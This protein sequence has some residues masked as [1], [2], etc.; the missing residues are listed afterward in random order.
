MTIFNGVAR[1]QFST[2]IAT[3]YL[4]L[5]VLFS[6]KLG[7]KISG[8][9]KI[10]YLIL[11]LISNLIS[12][13]R[14]LIAVYF[15]SLFLYIL[16]VPLKEK[17]R[18]ALIA[19]S[20]LISLVFICG[21]ENFYNGF[22]DRYT[23][24]STQISDSIRIEQSRSL[25]KEYQATPYFGKGLGGYAKD[26]IRSTTGNFNMHSYEVQWLAFLMQFGIVGILLIL[27]PICLIAFRLI[28]PQ[29]SLISISF[30]IL[31]ALWI[32]SGFTNPYL[33]SMQSGAIYTLFAIIPHQ[34]HATK[35]R[36]A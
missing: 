28:Y 36:F 17:M 26:S 1:I 30:L 20:L 3:P 16:S 21:P 35:L 24:K 19:C 6:E 10:L 13:S 22:V 34:I 29:P 8:K 27:S 18:G 2:D 15:I 33:I 12:Y 5:F 23:G 25:L 9:F 7:Q 31:F 32:G 4:I 11:S 14:F